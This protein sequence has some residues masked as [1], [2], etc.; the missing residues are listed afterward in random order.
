M[1]T[2]LTDYGIKA[3]ATV[4]PHSGILRFT[5]PAHTQSRIQIDLARRVGG[6]S[7]I[8]YVKIENEYTIRGWMKCPPE[9][10]GWGNGN[11]KADYTVYFYAVFSKPLK[12]YGFWSAN[13]P[14]DWSRKRQEVTSDIY[15][16]QVAQAPIIKNV[17]EIEGKHVGFFT[18]FATEANEAVTMKVGISFVDMAGAE[19]NYKQEI[20][21]KDFDTIRTE[22]V[23]N[24]NRELSRMEIEG[25][26]EE[27]K[28]IFYTSLYHTMLDPRITSDVDGRYVGADGKIHKS[29]SFTKRTIFSGWDVFRSQFPLQTL[30]NPD[31]VNDEI[32][33]LISIA[34]QSEK[35]Y[36]PRWELLNA[37]SGCM[38]GNPAVS[39]LADAYLKGI[40]GYDADKAY[41]YALNTVVRFGNGDI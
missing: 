2:T 5:Y 6:T 28:T 19:K 22:A 33:S 24:W 14:N 11:G 30:I 15:L 27:E 4:A 29:E 40:R 31:M 20:S 41:K 38:I 36:Y 17:S 7:T 8:Q 37:Y 32:N 35:K 3:E 12:N 21:L 18:E 25:G 23:E 16:Q 1:D 13:I 10:G 9:G 39:V 26:S 34:E